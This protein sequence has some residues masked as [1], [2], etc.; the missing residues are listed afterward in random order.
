MNKV[1]KFQSFPQSLIFHLH[2]RASSIPLSLTFIS[3]SLLFPF[4][5]MMA[6][7]SPLLTQATTHLRPPQAAP[8][9]PLPSPSPSRRHQ[10]VG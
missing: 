10:E 7:P 3:L 5:S 4:F 2:A 6:F 1:S 8:L 9:L